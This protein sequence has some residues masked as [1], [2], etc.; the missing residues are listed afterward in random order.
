MLENSTALLTVNGLLGGSLV[1][2][3]GALLSLPVR[4]PVYRLRIVGVTLLATLIAVGVS[5][6][7]GTP[8][9]SPLT[10][11]QQEAVQNVIVAPQTDLTSTAAVDG[12]AVSASSSRSRSSAARET[13]GSSFGVYSVGDDLTAASPSSGV[14]LASPQPAISQFSRPV[15]PPEFIPQLIRVFATG[16]LASVAALLLWWA[17]GVIL[18]IRVIRAASPASPSIQNLLREIAGDESGTVQ[19]V[20]SRAIRQPVACRASGRVILL[21]ESLARSGSRQELRFAIAHE[22]SHIDRGDWWLWSLANLLRAAFLFH[23]A[24]WWLRRQVRLC[25]DFLA[26]ARAADQPGCRIDYAEF[27]TKQAAVR[28]QPFLA[29]G[30]GMRGR[31]S[32]LYQRVLLLV[33]RDRPIETRCPHRWAWTVLI[34]FLSVGVLAGSGQVLTGESVSDRKPG[35][36]IKTE[37]TV[38][39]ASDQ[40]TPAESPGQPSTFSEPAGGEVLSEGELQVQFEDQGESLCFQL[41]A[42]SEPQGPRSLWWEPSGKPLKHNS[43]QRWLSSESMPTQPLEANARVF[44]LQFW[45]HDRVSIRWQIDGV[46]TSLLSSESVE[47]GDRRLTTVLFGGTFPE[48]VH[49][50]TVQVGYAAGSWRTAVVLPGR[51]HESTVVK[52]PGGAVTGFEIPIPGLTASQDIRVVADLESGAEE[53]ARLVQN[54]SGSLVAQFHGFRPGAVREYRLE[55]RPFRWLR[56]ENVSLDSG[57]KAS[58]RVM[59]DSGG[60]QSLGD[61]TVIAGARES[62]RMGTLLNVD[63]V[64]PREEL[65]Y[66]GRSFRQW[67]R[68]LQ[69]ELNPMRRA[70]AMRAFSAFGR[71]G[72]AKE[73]AGAILDATQ[74]MRRTTDTPW[75]EP[76]DR[77]RQAALVALLDLNPATVVEVLA[78]RMDR[79]AEENVEFIATWLSAAAAEKRTAAGLKRA[80]TAKR[81]DFVKAAESVDSERRSVFSD[82][83]RRVVPA[84]SRLK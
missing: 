55:S 32:E 39:A 71:N 26:D 25:Q 9:W 19:L 82:A 57:T 6:L 51:A 62:T 79:L 22:W 76:A 28:R 37:S 74:K 43:L 8:R 83:L 84:D 61:R 54:E 13:P 12:P 16:Y 14:P 36:S 2:L 70:E 64:P 38:E 78:G 24:A 7:P 20:V 48:K 49:V 46:A 67:R 47:I 66:D 65:R 34:V 81:D 73:A 50:A 30:L 42:V 15:L 56:F 41:T 45:K 72:Y 75:E 80:I 31:R 63:T 33:K 35:S 52:Q 68:E 17:I 60:P 23:P 53:T 4:E 27:L 44:L 10:S 29:A 40:Q 18:L 58:C 5:F 69:T 3:A 59:R 11:A 21:P 1:L 77:F